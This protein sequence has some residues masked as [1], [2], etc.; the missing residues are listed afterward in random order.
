MD[1][2]Q[3][4]VEAKI[5]NSLHGFASNELVFEDFTQPA[6]MLPPLALALESEDLTVVAVELSEYNKIKKKLIPAMNFS[7]EENE[8][9]KKILLENSFLDEKRVASNSLFP[10]EAKIFLSGDGVYCGFA[11]K[12]GAQIFMIL[13]LDPQRI[14]DMLKD[15]VVPFLM[16]ETNQETPAPLTAEGE[17]KNATSNP[18]L[19]AVNLLKEA[20]TKVA[21]CGNKQAKIIAECGE[22]ISG[23]DDIFMFTPHVEDRGD[24]DI[25]TYSVQLSRVSRTLSHTDLGAVISDVFEDENGSGVCIA[26]TDGDKAIVRRFY[27]EENESEDSVVRAAAIEAITLLGQNA[28]GV[29][30]DNASGES[31]TEEEK[32]ADKKTIKWVFIALAIVLVLCIAAGIGFNFL[33]ERAETTTT[34]TTT[35]TTTEPTTEAPEQ[36][37]LLKGVIDIMLARK[38]GEEVKNSDEAPEFFI[39]NGAKVD[40]KEALALIVQ[41]S[42]HKDDDWKEEALKA[43]IVAVF[44]DLKYKNNDWDISDVTMANTADVEVREA[45]D[46]VYGD[47]ISYKGNVAFTP[48]HRVSAGKTASSESI[49]GKAFDYLVS[50]NSSTDKKQ[51]VYKTEVR[52]A[53]STMSSQIYRATSTEEFESNPAE[54][55]KINEHDSAVSKDVGY[56]TKI[57]AADTIMSGYKF[58]RAIDTNGQLS[59][60]CFSVSYDKDAKE[61]VFTVYGQGSGVGMS[62]LGAN[63]MAGNK[64]D[65]DEILA[66]Y[67]PGTVLVQGA[68]SKANAENE[69]TTTT[70]RTATTTKKNTTTAST[71]EPT[72][73]S[74]TASTTEPTT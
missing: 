11:V 7:L 63:S 4:K 5:S 14:T 46:K 67:Y 56:V 74:T 3:R 30:E 53:S 26:I 33:S 64:K 50:V 34:E 60:A 40:A 22:G 24:I 9:V 41:A 72:T 17:V 12:S 44:T 52:I 68:I 58:V 35:V 21:F 70:A 57:K 13:P 6:E 69:K 62:Q 54:W 2:A 28:Y 51:S 27:A 45:V 36:A 47:Y 25:V 19:R 1:I 31:V 39:K 55:I 61:F 65:Y 71:T 38:D 49:Y 16:D 20:N 59:S 66:Y 32:I 42:I 43:Q 29:L 15:G 48:F 10:K 73:E 18:V 8:E 37:D 23:F